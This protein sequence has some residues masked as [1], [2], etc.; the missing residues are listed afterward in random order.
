MTTTH[1][2]DIRAPIHPRQILSVHFQEFKVP[3]ANYSWDTTT[4][5]LIAICTDG[6]MWI[7]DIEDAAVSYLSISEHAA[8]QRL[9]IPLIPQGNK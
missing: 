4:V 9:P 7:L 1:H 8:W 2:I 5:R 3:R 6:T